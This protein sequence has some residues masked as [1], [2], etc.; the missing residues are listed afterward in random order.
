M[1]DILGLNSFG[2]ASHPVRPAQRPAPVAV[3]TGRPDIA[4]PNPSH[5]AGDAARRFPALDPLPGPPP[6]FEA[7]LLELESN[8]QSVI[9]R[10]EA[11]HERARDLHAAAPEHPSPTPAEPPRL[12]PAL[13]SDGTLRK[14]ETPH[15]T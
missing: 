14:Q 13:E 1:P 3:D 6:A 7:S 9:K 5:H 4:A 8:L 11:A 15:P 2:P 12:N 10:V